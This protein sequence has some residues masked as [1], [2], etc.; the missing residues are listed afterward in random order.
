[1]KVCVGGS[2]GAANTLA[3]VIL[4]MA[5]S[6]PG[7]WCPGSD[8]GEVRLIARNGSGCF[9]PSPSDARQRNHLVCVSGSRPPSCGAPS[10]ALSVLLEI[11]VQVQS[12]VCRGVWRQDT[13]WDSRMRC[14][15]DGPLSPTVCAVQTELEALSEERYIRA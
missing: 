5:S 10:H 7:R 15:V 13:R 4:L 3:K 14:N 8:E 12:G 11:Q 1:M 2:P 6:E 9:E